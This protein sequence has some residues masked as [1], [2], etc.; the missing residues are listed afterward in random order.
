MQFDADVSLEQSGVRVVDAAAS[1]MLY[2]AA[3]V[4]L[5]SSEDRRDSPPH[6][7]FYRD[8]PMG[9]NAEKRPVAPNCQGGRWR[10]L[11]MACVGA[12][13]R[14]AF[15]A[16]SAAAACFAEA[17]GGS[18]GE[19][20][21]GVAS[22]VAGPGRLSWR[23]HTKS[24]ARPGGATIGAPLISTWVAIES[25]TGGFDGL[26]PSSSSGVES[27]TVSVTTGPASGEAFAG[28]PGARVCG[29]SGRGSPTGVGRASIIRWS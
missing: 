9:Q 13:L 8:D 26:S 22:L 17:C 6:G 12:C 15:G 29:G 21:S 4:L 18:I 5:R 28:T 2:E 19:L 24:S 23:G 1:A 3:N 10:D 25:V 14:W 16:G 7:G 27:V 11:G 20:G